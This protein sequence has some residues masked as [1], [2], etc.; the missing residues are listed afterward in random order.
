MLLQC[1][2][3]CRGCMQSL[4]DIPMSGLAPPPPSSHLPRMGLSEYGFF[5]SHQRWDLSGPLCYGG[6]WH[7]SHA[8][9]LPR[10]QIFAASTPRPW[11]C[12]PALEDCIRGSLGGQ[13][14]LPV[15]T[16]AEATNDWYR[17]LRRTDVAL[18]KLCKVIEAGFFWWVSILGGCHLTAGSF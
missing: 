5:C 13:I 2:S 9:G 12:K 1:C 14:S 3:L 11:F 10:R 16:L 17:K 6:R 4:P 18:A 8:C 7:C 15:P